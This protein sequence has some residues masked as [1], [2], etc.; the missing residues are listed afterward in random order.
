MTITLW[1]VDGMGENND[2]KN[3]IIT[4]Q[5]INYINRTDIK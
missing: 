2:Y 4:I 3:V 5:S 1:I